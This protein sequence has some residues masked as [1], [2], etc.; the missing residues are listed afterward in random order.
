MSKKTLTHQLHQ[1]VANIHTRQT[2]NLDVNMP[3]LLHQVHQEPMHILVRYIYLLI[4]PLSCVANHRAMVMMMM[5][6][7]R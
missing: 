4:L 7:N 3:P 1:P 5:L 2:H 6:P